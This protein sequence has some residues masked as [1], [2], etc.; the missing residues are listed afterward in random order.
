MLKC[1]FVAIPVNKMQQGQLTWCWY[2]SI[3]S[4]GIKTGLAIKKKKTREEKGQNLEAHVSETFVTK[5]SDQL[6]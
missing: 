1:S 4:V 5:T 2:E 6:S 3:L